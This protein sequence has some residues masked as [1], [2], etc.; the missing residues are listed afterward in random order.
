[1]LVCDCRYSRVAWWGPLQWQLLACRST[2][3]ST[4]AALSKVQPFLQKASATTFSIE[5]T[6]ILNEAWTLVL[7][8]QRPHGP[9]GAP[10]QTAMMLGCK[11]QWPTLRPFGSG[12]R[13]SFCQ[14]GAG[15][16]PIAEMGKLSATGMEKECAPQGLS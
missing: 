3:R 14:A 7:C 12:R 11:L 8:G 16:A 13:R 15:T 2:L 10:A 5:V 1:M 6:I 9:A 4:S